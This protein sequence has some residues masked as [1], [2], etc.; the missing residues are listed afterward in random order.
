MSDSLVFSLCLREKANSEVYQ[1]RKCWKNLMWY[2][3]SFSEKMILILLN[4][5]K[6]SPDSLTG[7]Q[8]CKT[9]VQKGYDLMVVTDAEENEAEEERETAKAMTEVSPGS[10]KVLRNDHF[11]KLDN[12]D[13]II[14]MA[15]SMINSAIKFK[16]NFN[17]RLIL[18]AFAK[19][20]PDNEIFE[21]AKKH[22]NELWSVGPDIF[23]YHQQ[24]LNRKQIDIEHKSA[25][26]LPD[27]NVASSL[28]NLKQNTMKVVSLWH[29]GVQYT[30]NGKRK[31]IPGS[32]FQRF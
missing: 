31:R 6:D 15:P 12:V 27:V 5:F 32:I 21:W 2:V 4:K 3:L 24:I 22:V 18:V 26:L 1:F 20:L 17:C 10:I 25:L 16:A 14:G 8:L 29:E 30:L 23:D 13:T 28:K 9:L 7:F 11:S 19:I